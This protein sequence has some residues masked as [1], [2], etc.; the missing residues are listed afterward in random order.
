MKKTTITNLIVGLLLITGLNAQN[1]QDGVY[2]LYANREKTAVDKFQ[3]LIATNPNNIEATYWL[4]QAY[5]ELDDNDIACHLYEKAISTNGRAPMLLVGLGHAKLLDKKNSEAMQL[6]NEALEASKNRKGNDPE[7]AAKI[8][9]AI[10]DSKTGDFKFAIQLLLEATGKDPKNTEILLQL[11]NAYRKADPGKGGSD[12]YIYYNKALEV[13]PSFSPALVRLAKLFETQQNWSFVLQYLT[14]AVTRDPKFTNAYYELY[15]YY[16]LRKDYKE[17]DNQLQKYIESK[18]P[19]TDILDEYLYGQL[20][21]VAKDFD[22]AITKGNMVVS[23]MGEK[24]KPRVYKLLAYAYFDKADYQLA[25]NNVNKYFA[26]EKPD[27][28]V[29]PDYTLMAGI[30][31]KTGGTPDVIYNTYIKGAALD[32]VLNSKIDFLKQGA[33]AFEKMEDSVSRAKE[34]DIRSLIITLKP[35]P[36]LTDYYYTGFAYYKAGNYPKAIKLFE[37]LSE[38]YPD[39]IYGPE[40]LFQIHRIL[41]STMEKGLAVP[42]ALKYLDVLSKDT[43]KNKN[44][45]IS[46]S[47]YLATYYANVAK[48]YEKAV[49]YLEKMLAFDPTN[50]NIQKNIDILKKAITPKAKEATIP[51]TGS[52]NPPVKK[53]TNTKANTKSATNNSLVKSS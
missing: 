20:C 42:Y 46:T 31:A 38:K 11:G 23:E 25:L 43:I 29:P 7:V 40:R 33:E 30:L 52:T 3:K 19:E 44:E 49:E 47:S 28:L 18:K 39:E 10:V 50:V 15:W 51:K 24:T 32:T 45:I 2:D 17:A 27:E 37:T 4:G 22:C 36:A 34:G 8:G 1:I 14:Q 26:K 5:F 6:F 53:T 41:D 13:N 16:F 12:A 35:E 9:R 21:W 48:D